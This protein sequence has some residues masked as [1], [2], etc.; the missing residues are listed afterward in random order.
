MIA[1]KVALVVSIPAMRSFLRLYADIGLSPTEAMFVLHLMDHRQ[2]TDQPMFKAE[3]LAARMQ[4]SVPQ[5]KRYIRN[6]EQK[7]IRTQYIHA[8][9]SHVFD[10]TGLF[11][12]I[13]EALRARRKLREQKS[14]KAKRRQL[15]PDVLNWAEVRRMRHEAL[16]SKEKT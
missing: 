3:L 6:L 10:L 5:L 11:K 12:R 13:E 8:K 15:P 16:S 1:E 4:I 14:G 2:D 9:Y 7:G